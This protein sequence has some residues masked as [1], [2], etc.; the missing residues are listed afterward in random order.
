MNF[1]NPLY[2]LAGLAALV[3]LIIHLLHRQRAR[4]EVFPSL[5]FLRRMMRRRTRRF[6]LK[7]ILLLLVRILLVLFIALA[8]ARPTLTGGRAVTG[9]LP[10]TAVVILDDSYSMQRTD[11]RGSL[12][13][14]ALAEALDLMDYFDRSD[15]VHVLT[16]SKPSRELSASGLSDLEGLRTVLKEAVCTDR[17]TD[18]ASPLR[19]AL[20]ILEASSRPNREIYIISDMQKPAWAD[21]TEALD[22]GGLDIKVLTVDV[23]TG[24][25]NACVDDIAF[26]IPAGTDNL[27]MQV[28]FK[29]FNSDAAQ[30]RVA[31]V[32]LRD[33]LL[34]RAVFEGGEAS[35]AAEIFSLPPAE[36]FLWGEVAMAEDRLPVDDRRYYAVP[37][38]KRSVGV[39]GEAYYIETA[40]SPEG[41]GGF[42]WTEMEEGALS[43]AG[44]AAV[45]A[46]VISDVP[47][48]SP[49]E[50]DAL[51]DF[52]MAGGGVLIFL[53]GAVDIGAYN[54]N[55]LPRLG[56]IRIEGAS[57]AGGGGF[58]TIDRYD[59]GHP[60]FDKFKPGTNPFSD[61][62]FY[63]FMKVREGAGRVLAYF[64]DG[65]PAM[66]EVS[67]HVIVVTTP[68][69]VGWNDFALTSQ[70]L[71]VLHET[72][73]YLTSKAG[74]GRSYILGEEILI[75]DI[76]AEGDVML[77]GPTGVVR[78]FPDIGAGGMALAVPSPD[79][80]GI[81][82]LKTERETLSVFAL[83]VD[84]S[85]SD[86]T[87]MGID[88][89]QA[90]LRGFDIRQAPP[91]ED[92]GESVSILR[93]GRDL[94]RM[95]LWA[96]LVLIGLETL[97]AS[98][99]WQRP[100][101]ASDDDAFTNS[102]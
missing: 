57:P 102:R 35:T 56:D 79:Q 29:R 8:L 40:L 28:G 82:F 59:E 7:Q 87:K 89:M 27:I 70:F 3:P 86:L 15:E 88:Q 67:D 99:L 20:A 41:G 37:S 19:Q 36:G 52:V 84:T 50:V 25:A 39:V 91:T 2:L 38:R 60:I 71:P 18:L 6:H 42:R 72:L 90:K 85:E 74:L 75:P 49:L 22:A 51:A 10:T 47:R 81:Y 44:L 61:T 58:Y 17:A 80:P 32:F 14:E 68:P 76:T 46:L 65:S 55:L 101:A 77:V 33:A 23:G 94:A 96:A 78:H 73:L 95:F 12:F 48:L 54:R 13:D 62:R 9:H 43:R 97:L 1:L 34:D 4:I 11:G 92:I 100:K 66:V 31:E 21:L 69:E 53:G 24:V 26:R 83:N 64:S 45:D 5:E 30:G 98:S 63:Q 16:A 93:Q